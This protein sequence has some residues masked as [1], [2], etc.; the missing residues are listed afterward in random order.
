MDKVF[1]IPPM[2][3]KYIIRS[4]DEEVEVIAFEQSSNGERSDNDWLTYI[5]SNN[6]ERIKEHLNIQLDFK[7]VMNDTWTKIFDYAKPNKYPTTMNNRKFEVAKELV[8]NKNM[9]VIGAV[10]TA[11]A[12][13]KQVGIELE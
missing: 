7:P 1:S 10:S 3:S 8:I 11:D 9:T 6:Q 4:T 13:V 5:D 12:L 2:A